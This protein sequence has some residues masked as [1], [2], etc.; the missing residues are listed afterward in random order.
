LFFRKA[1]AALATFRL[2]PRHFEYIELDE[3]TDLPGDKMQDEFERRYGTR[4]VP[5]VFIGG[6]LIGG[7]D[8]VVRLLHEGVLE[9]LVNSALGIQ[10]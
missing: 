7:G 4:S 10:N 8:D 6:E 3:R 5:K 1:K 2:N 9:V